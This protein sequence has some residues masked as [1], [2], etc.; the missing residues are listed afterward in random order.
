MGLNAVLYLENDS[1]YH[2]HNLNAIS[3]Q[4]MQQSIVVGLKLRA[5]KALRQRS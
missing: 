2:F 5:E 4:K 1:K 3:E